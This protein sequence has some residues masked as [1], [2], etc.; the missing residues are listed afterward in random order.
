MD[1]Y[2]ATNSLLHYNKLEKITKYVLVGDSHQNV[3]FC[4]HRIVAPRDSSIARL[5]VSK[6]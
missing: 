2:L 3:E 6:M 5:V 4:F 1:L